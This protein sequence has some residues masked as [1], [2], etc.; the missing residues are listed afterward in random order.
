M[1]LDISVE[2]KENKA[3]ASQSS[4]LN[5]SSTA[6]SNAKPISVLELVTSKREWWHLATL[7][8]ATGWYELLIQSTKAENKQ[9][10]QVTE[11]RPQASV[12]S[13]TQ[14]LNRTEV[15]KRKCTMLEN[16]VF[17]QASESL[18]LCESLCKILESLPVILVGDIRL[19][20]VL[21]ELAAVHWAK[22]PKVSTQLFWSTRRLLTRLF[23]SEVPEALCEHLVN[24][25]S[26]FSSWFRQLKE[27]KQD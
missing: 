3:A 22:A 21:L 11:L 19:C 7:Q 15:Y 14:T 12:E 16:A 13:K 9:T 10:S 20:G 17:L 25:A 24:K 2:H 26:L 27:A 8:E 5:P 4:T 18:E 1:L 23:Q 6:Q